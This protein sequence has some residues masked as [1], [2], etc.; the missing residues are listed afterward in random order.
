MRRRAAGYALQ[1]DR[2]RVGLASM[3]AIAEKFDFGGKSFRMK[4]I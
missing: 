1:Q 4:N 2:R 3:T